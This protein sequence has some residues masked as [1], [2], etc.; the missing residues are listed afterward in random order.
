MKRDFKDALLLAIERGIA[1]PTGDWRMFNA[2]NLPI[3]NEVWIAGLECEQ[4]FRGEFLKLQNSGSNVSPKLDLSDKHQGAIVVAGR[5]RRV[6]ESNITRA[7]NACENGGQVVIAGDKTAGI[8]P[9]RNWVSRKVEIEESFS[10]HHAIV[11]SL[12]K[13]GADWPI[14]SLEKQLE[15]YWLSD[16]MFSS[17]GP[18]T[19]SKLLVAHFDNRIG[20]AVADLGAGWGYLS[21]ELLRRSQKVK[22]LRL[23]E[24]DYCSI[25]A[26]KQNLH[27]T[28][29]ETDFIWCDV[30]TEF[31]KRPYNW[32]IMNPPFHAG[33]VADPELGK[34]FIQTA[35][36]TLPT[37]GKLLM[38]A[39]RKLP[40]E[41]TLNKLFRNHQIIAEQDG[42]KVLEATK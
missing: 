35:A 4:G 20:G 2:C 29:V 5:N 12:R 40:Y 34:R 10:K 7:W 22:Q 23:F 30:T 17:D 11:F 19:G 3:M 8:N 13:E 36:S 39:N 6:N 14:I 18:D 38:V 1:E 37:G 28:T 21:N 15:G 33:R 9:L 25:E 16:G 26:A 24:A 41:E 32:V 27:E 42:F 31:P